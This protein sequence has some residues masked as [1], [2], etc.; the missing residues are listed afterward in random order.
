ML[1]RII[2]AAG[3]LAAMA[4]ILAGAPFA[5]LHLG[6][7]P[8][9]AAT[10]A[11]QHLFDVDHS[12]TVLLGAITL[13][14]WIAW[15]TFVQAFVAALLDYLRPGGRPIPAISAQRALFTVLLGAVLTTTAT[16]GSWGTAASL[17]APPD[18]PA[19]VALHDAATPTPVQGDRAPVVHQGPGADRGDAL[20]HTVQRGEHLL[21][22]AERYYGSADEFGR[23][24]AA[25]AGVT[26]PD[27]R[28]L[29]HGQTLIR[30]GWQL[31][32]PHPS[33]G[34][35]D[36]DSVEVQAGTITLVANQQAHEVQVKRGDNLFTLAQRWLG[37]GDRWPEIYKLNKHRH[38]DDGR[39]L[40]TPRLIHPGWTLDLPDDARPPGHTKPTTPPDQPKP[41]ADPTQPAE[42]APTTPP[43]PTAPT[44]PPP[45]TPTPG[46]PGDDGVVTVPPAQTRPTDTPTATPAPQRPTQPASSPVGIDLPG[47]GWVDVG[48][49]AALAG[50]GALVWAHR[51]RRYRPGRGHGLRRADPDLRPLPALIRHLRARLTP[52]PTA[53]ATDSAEPIE[54]WVDDLKAPT[55][56]DPAVPVTADLPQHPDM[57]ELV[58]A[59]TDDVDQD[60]AVVNAGDAQPVA[61]AITGQHADLWP[62]AGLGLTGP[63]AHAAARGMLVAALAAGQPDLPHSRTRVIITAGT[64]ASL[65][66][67][68][69]VRVPESGRLE[70]TAGLEEALV[71]V[72][73]EALCRARLC[74][75]HDVF[76]IADLRE[77]TDAEDL[78]PLLLITDVGGAPE[79]TRIAWSLSHHYRLDIHG[80]LLGGWT[81][82]DTVQVDA[83]GTTS[84]PDRGG[85]AERHR[86]GHGADLGRLAVMDEDQTLAALTT[87]AEAHNGEPAPDPH[88][89]APAVTLAGVPVRNDEKADP[90]AGD[91]TPE[92]DA[93]DATVPERDDDGSPT[94][95]PINGHPV[96]AV[97]AAASGDD[98]PQPQDSDDDPAP[99][100]GRV[101]VMLLGR[102]TLPDY[103]RPGKLGGRGR[104]LE[105]L[106]YL[107]VNG[108]ETSVDAVLEDLVPDATFSKA[109]QRLAAAVYSF[110]QAMRDFGDGEFLDRD[111]RRVGLRRDRFDIDVWRMRDNLTK[112]KAAHS[113]VQR[114]R[115]LR[116][117][118]AAYGG[119]F[120]EGENKW[121]WA[122]LPREAV[123]RD[124][125]DIVLALA[126]ELAAQPHDALAV[127]EPAIAAH[128]HTEVLYQEAMRAHAALGDETGIKRVRRDLTRALESID[129]E[130]EDDTRALA[131]QLLAEVARRAGRQGR[132][133][134]R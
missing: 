57:D 43:A 125:I 86:H 78:P 49:A 74:Q 61:P 11:G 89:E 102:P 110:R 5:L 42:P 122:D 105:L 95:A 66:G 38:F 128:P 115:L 64:L 111:E 88:P 26:Q 55:A 67:A 126:Q 83:D 6:T 52:T 112:A 96:P 33:H 27:G 104:A 119:T 77:R 106:A 117:A 53:P 76:S 13:V 130:P 121:D 131:A 80:V 32:I 12:N 50:V 22:L 40:H 54:A 39:T 116:R 59:G 23:I 75:E 30:E 10:W 24:V 81:H 14:G 47:G 85:V 41:P 134:R 129:A 34:L 36:A 3:A 82:G 46:G 123:R 109:K 48:L 60:L 90:T 16:A 114:V 58:A 71:E 21:D 132:G 91:G 20:V 94:R 35:H 63:G 127:L 17:P 4:A 44:T 100:D 124:H 92:P 108:G 15:L 18:R 98:E 9:T 31:R 107:A 133:D 29:Q 2:K 99:A 87:L 65:L 56:D 28:A 120:A 101:R 62:T 72:E 19:A 8:W 7:N 118:V 37:D 69:A 93:D 25:N 103:Q 70:V 51:R 97:T 79:Q 113:S 73:Q 1:T 68:N 84:R 45:A